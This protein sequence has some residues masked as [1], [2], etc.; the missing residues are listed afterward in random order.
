MARISAALAAAQLETVRQTGLKV[1]LFD[2]EIA[3]WQYLTGDTIPL[4]FFQA[5][6]GSYQVWEKE[7]YAY[8]GFAAMAVLGNGNIFRIRCGDPTDVSDRQLWYQEITDP[9]G[10]AEWESWDVLYSG[11]HYGA[12]AVMADGNDPIVYHSKADGIYRN[13]VKQW[14]P[15]SGEAMGFIPVLNH[16]DA[17][18]VSVLYEDPFDGHATFDL[19]YTEDLTSVDPTRDDSN[20]RWRNRPALI[21][22]E[23]DNGKIARIQSGQLY[24]DS[25]DANVGTALWYQEQ[26]AIDDTDLDPPRVIRGVGGGAGRNKYTSLGLLECSDGFYYLH[27]GESYRQIIDG[28]EE[29]ATNLGLLRTWLRSKD[30]INWTESTVG[31][32]AVESNGFAGVVESDGSVFW[33]DSGQVWRRFADVS[34]YNLE[35]YI[36]QISYSFGGGKQA[37]TG[38]ALVANPDGENDWLLE[39]SDRRILVEPGIRVA[40]G[41]YEFASIAPLYLKRCVRHTE[42]E[43]NRITMIFGD[44]WSRLESELKDTF[45]FVGKTEWDDFDAGK[46]NHLYNYYYHTDTDP[47]VNGNNNLESS[48]RVLFTG[49]K[50]HNL[51]FSVDFISGSGRTI[52]ARY[53]DAD[54]FVKM[55]QDGSYLKLYEIHEGNEHF[56]TQAAISPETPNRMRLR[57]EWN[58]YWMYYGGNLE[59]SGTRNWRTSAPGYVG[60]SASGAHETDTWNFEDWEFDL[61]LGH[62]IE[63]ALALADIHDVAVQTAT[64]RAYAIIWGP[65]TDVQTPAEALRQILTG[66]KLEISYQTNKYV[67]N[68]YNDRTVVHTLQDN[69]ISSTEED[70]SKEEINFGIVDGNEHFWMHIDA[71]DIAN[72]GRQILRRYD[73]PELLELSAVKQRAEEEVTNSQRTSAPGGDIVMLFD[74]WPMDYVRWIDNVGNSKVARVDQIDVKINQSKTPF[75]RMTITTVVPTDEINNYLP[76]IES[77]EGVGEPS[78]VQAGIIAP[79]ALTP[80][81]TFGTPEMA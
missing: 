61:Q 9:N 70:E 74:L 52:L 30:L 16:L 27:C 36:P 10:A 13:N 43:A 66:L 21:G 68:K 73:V 2:E 11:N 71:E 76:S 1:T 23:L 51:D 37:G 77:A 55:V 42:G 53:K 22:W 31:P 20:F 63:V 54:N 32:G 4:S 24:H 49:W 39:L 14:E 7:Y 46:P 72:R 38:E 28:E 64:G 50:G 26:A 18:W 44:V 33:G 3:K 17:G 5:A 47:E 12:L 78:I 59:A 60:I 69:V 81:E 8:R 67:V 15:S 65:S 19:W 58:R 6:A 35:D 75:Q 25:R 80:S 56:I 29:Y 62:L 48:G 57:L 34:E 41:S 79:V 40:D 45:N